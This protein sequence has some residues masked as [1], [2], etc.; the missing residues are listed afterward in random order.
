MCYTLTETDVQISNV[1]PANKRTKMLLWSYVIV[2]I[3]FS[4]Y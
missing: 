4:T 2:C 3:S 1:E